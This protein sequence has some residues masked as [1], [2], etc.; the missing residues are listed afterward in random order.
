MRVGDYRI[1]YEVVDADR[2]VLILSIIHRKDLE[3]WLRQHG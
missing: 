3:H 1:M 2:V